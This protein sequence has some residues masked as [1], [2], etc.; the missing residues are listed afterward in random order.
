[1][2]VPIRSPARSPVQRLSPGRPLL[3]SGIADG[4]EGL[5]LADLARAI[6]AGT[7]APAISLAV[8]CRDGARMAMLARALAFFAPDI[9]VLEF[10]AWDCLPYD[11]VSPHAG[12]VAQRMAVLAR[13]AP[14][15]YPPPLAGVGREGD[16][17]A[18]P[19]GRP[20]PLARVSWKDRMPLRKRR[21]E[22]T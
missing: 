12:V 18:R 14:P 6:A 21:K 19:H 8:I 1:M 4:A 5:V 20:P 17:P 3:L 9:E 2:T 16:A 13:L 11:R 22:G 7:A 15:P 10:P